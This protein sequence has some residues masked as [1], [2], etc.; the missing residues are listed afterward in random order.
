[1][2]DLLMERS[3]DGAVALPVEL[4]DTTSSLSATL[5]LLLSSRLLIVN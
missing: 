4:V 1:M 5:S 3:A 2:V